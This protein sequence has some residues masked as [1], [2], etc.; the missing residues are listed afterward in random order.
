MS[1]KR[2][3]LKQ[4]SIKQEKSAMKIGTDAVLLGA[5][6]SISHFQDKILDIG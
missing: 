2:F 3:Q 6:C 5:W 4:F 1:I